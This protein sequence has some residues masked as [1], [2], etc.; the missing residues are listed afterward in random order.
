MRTSRLARKTEMRLARKN[1][2]HPDVAGMA[3]ELGR[4]LPGCSLDAQR[5]LDAIVD[6]SASIELPGLLRC[7]QGSCLVSSFVF[8][9]YSPDVCR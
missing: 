4:A 6:H 9:L 3:V 8:L 1:E 5:A 2:S 7:D